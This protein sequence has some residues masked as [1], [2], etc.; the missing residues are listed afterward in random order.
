[1]EKINVYIELCREGV[2]IPRYANIFDA[3]MDVCAA[4]DAVIEPGETIIIPAGFKLAIPE[5][6]EIQV[7]PRSG[8]SFKTPLR[9]SNSPG[10]IDSGYRDEVGILM[11]NTSDKEDKEIILPL[12]SSGNKSGT[13]DIKK[14]DR[15]AQLVLARVPQ[16]EF[17][18]I[19]DVRTIGTDRGGGFGSTGV[20]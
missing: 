20:K 16:I 6:F 10:T 8:L 5:G 13:Y 1:M 4:V 3:G 19:E 7:R 12:S 11:T 14:G 15:I 18:K 17:I 2:E 9:L